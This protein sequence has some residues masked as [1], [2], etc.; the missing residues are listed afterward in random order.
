[1]EE[2]TTGGWETQPAGGSAAE[3]LHCMKQERLCNFHKVITF[4]D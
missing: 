4:G 2:Q 1:M 3:H